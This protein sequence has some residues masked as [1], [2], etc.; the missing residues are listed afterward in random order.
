MQSAA[1]QA[2]KIAKKTSDGA[3]AVTLAT[4]GVSS[5]SGF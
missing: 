1:E 5:C 3:N 2:D 4:G